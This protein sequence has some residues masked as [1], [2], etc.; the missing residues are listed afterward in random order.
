M[1]NNDLI[2]RTIRGPHG[3]V[4]E[5]EGDETIG[6]LMECL[7]AALDRHDELVRQVNGPWQ[8]PAQGTT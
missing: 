4:L 1:S 2:R 8:K 5:P 3:T 6:D 7:K